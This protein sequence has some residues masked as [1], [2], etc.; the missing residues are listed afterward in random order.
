MR[1]LAPAFF[2][3]IAA[4]VLASCGGSERSAATAPNSPAKPG[5]IVKSV[6]PAELTGMLAK[7]DF[8]LVNVHIPYEGEIASTDAFIPYDQPDQLL[9]KLPA[10]RDAKIVLYCRSGRM[11]AIASETLAKN[12]YANLLDL[13]GGMVAWEDAGYEVIRK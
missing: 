10:N 11:S 12:G 1:H 4:V 3:L 8:V 2:V 9:S 6:T 13:T 7:K 5:A